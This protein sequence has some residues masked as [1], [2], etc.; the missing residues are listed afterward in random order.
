MIELGINKEC[1]LLLKIDETTSVMK[2]EV[3]VWISTDAKE[4]S[5]WLTCFSPHAILLEYTVYLAEVFWGLMN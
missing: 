5:M 3:S 1:Q 4:M 2:V